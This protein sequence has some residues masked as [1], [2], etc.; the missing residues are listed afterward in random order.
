[1]ILGYINEDAT[2]TVNDGGS[3][4]TGSDSNNNNE[5]ADTTG[6][7]LANDTDADGSSSLTVSAISGGTVG[8]ALTGTYGTLTL[9]ANGSYTYVANQSGAD[10]LSSLMLRQL[11]HLLILSVMALVRQ[12]LQH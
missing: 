11:I 7:V 8:Q 1:M 9:N 5:S 10:G 6:D 3:A 12:T 2:L 4:V